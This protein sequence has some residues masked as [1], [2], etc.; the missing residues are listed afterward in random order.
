MARRL[1]AELRTLLD[2]AL[3]AKDPAPLRAHHPALIA[4][5]DTPAPALYRLGMLEMAAGRVQAALPLVAA[6]AARAP[7]D[8]TILVNHAQVLLAAGRASDAVGRLDALPAAVRGNPAVARLTADALLADGALDRAAER[9]AQVLRAGPED[10]VVLTNFGVTLRRLGRFE[11]AARHLDRAVALAPLREAVVN[12][13]GLY[14][15]LESPGEAVDALDRALARAPGDP[16]LHH[17]LAVAHRAGGDAGAGETAIRR[18][19]ILAPAAAQSWG[20]AADAAQNR[21]D[22]ERAEA[23]SRRTLVCDA[24]SPLGR[25]VAVAVARRTN[26]GREAVAL[27][28]DWAATTEPATRHG[29][30]FEKAQALEGLGD[31][32]A[33]FAAFAAANANQR[34]TAAPVRDPARALDQVARLSAVYDAGLPAPARRGENSDGGSDLLFVVGF[35]RSG[36]TLLDQILD[37]HPAVTVI[38]ERPLVAAMIADLTATG[39]PYPEALADLGA[40]QA[41]ALAAA[42]RGRL[43]RHVRDP[44]AR[45]T[46]DKMPLNLVHV[47]LIRAVF[48]EARFVLALRHPCDVVLSCF[49]QNFRLNDWMA[50][51]STLEDAAALYAACFEAWQRYVSLVTTPH[52]TVRYEDV[53]ADVECEARRLLAF[54][55]LGF[56]ARVLAFH[57]H[58][59]TRGVLA[60]P[61]A[62]QVTRP[63]Y[64]SAVARWRRYDF[65]LAPVADRLAPLIERFGYAEEAGT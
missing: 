55:D 49:M 16:L 31:R 9:Y 60:T 58:A 4:A 45:Y 38:E 25:Q 28:E 11:E 53:V 8:A 10:P 59:R 35:P 15:Q 14:L 40:D 46:V 51:F 44:G 37:A 27:A 41:E 7:G 52:L 5:G 32:E 12:L 56:D 19:L 18:A 63:I 1:T 21:A 23:L 61:S 64:R 34:D 65:A 17:H 50:A 30:L 13:A 6:A 24:T 47:G 43:A 36:T 3:N 33:A 20:L 39:R 57:E 54:L 26:R 42:Y 22:L 62:A 48:P 29:L 2:R